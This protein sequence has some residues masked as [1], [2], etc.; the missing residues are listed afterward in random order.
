M[1]KF[2]LFNRIAKLKGKCT[3]LM[4][5][6]SLK[7]RLDDEL[8]NHTNCNDDNF[9]DLNILKQRLL[10]GDNKLTLDD[11]ICTCCFEILYNP[12]TLL[13]GH[14]ICQLC[15]ANWFL[16]SS[17]RIC[18]TCRQEWIGAPKANIVLK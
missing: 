18:P 1:S 7:Q 4:S 6:T 14:N 17:K 15:L 5:P 3:S 2:K 16:I 12:I 13:C 11:Y 10:N 8:N 9:D